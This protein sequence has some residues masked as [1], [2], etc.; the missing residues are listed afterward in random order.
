MPF[1]LLTPQI[2]SVWSVNLVFFAPKVFLLANFVKTRV[3]SQTAVQ[4][5]V[6]CIGL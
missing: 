4:L 5:S 2:L 1:C 6:P 3:V